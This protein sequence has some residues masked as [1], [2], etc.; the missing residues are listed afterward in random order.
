MPTSPFLDCQLNMLNMIRHAY[1]LRFRH[2]HR[3]DEE[4]FRVTVPLDT[5]TGALCGCVS[6]SC[7]R[8][9]IAIKHLPQRAAACQVL[10]CI[11]AGAGVQVRPQVLISVSVDREAGCVTFSS[12]TATLGTAHAF[13]K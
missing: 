6:S 4:T 12:Q 8:A 10:I 3:L 7:A 2:C 11:M 9:R 5:T 13:K 1:Q